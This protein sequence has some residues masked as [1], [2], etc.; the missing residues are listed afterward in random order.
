MET[1]CTNH[2]PKSN[3]GTSEENS[4][5]PSSSATRLNI[6]LSEVL[7]GLGRTGR[8]LRIPQLLLRIRN[9]IS[10]LRN[11]AP[12]VEEYEYLP[13]RDQT[14]LYIAN[15]V[16]YEL[17]PVFSFLTRGQGGFAI[18]DEE[19]ETRSLIINVDFWDYAKILVVIMSL[20][21]MAL[22]VLIIAKALYPAFYEDLR[23]QLVF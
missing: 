8:L 11:L 20:N 23:K 6:T 19:G 2:E 9:T 22:F 1:K 3:E 18:E 17:E 13:P 12:L 14:R 7:N 16:P 5:E 15:E 21:T 10:A 4:Q